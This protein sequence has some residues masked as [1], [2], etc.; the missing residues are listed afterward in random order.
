MRIAALPAMIIA[1]GLSACSAEVGNSAD[2]AEEATASTGQALVY[3]ANFG[4]TIDSVGAADTKCASLVECYL[5]HDKKVNW[6]RVNEGTSGPKFGIHLSDLFADELSYQKSNAPGWNIINDGAA[7]DTVED[8]ALPGLAESRMLASG[9]I[10]NV[11]NPNP[12]GGK[13]H[14]FHRCKVQ[15]DLSKIENRLGSSTFTQVNNYAH[16]VLRREMFACL[17]LGRGTGGPMVG[18]QPSAFRNGLIAVTSTQTT[19]LQ[20]YTP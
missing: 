12:P 1:L 13:R 10:D 18:G 8:A 14:M 5:Q 9:Q 15:I 2:G 17:G 6:K 19:M 20:Q 16:N 11:N 4:F 3:P 7:E